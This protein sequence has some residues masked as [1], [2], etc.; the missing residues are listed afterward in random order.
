MMNTLQ[1]L[2]LI[3]TIVVGI[4]SLLLAI[5]ITRVYARKKSLP[6]LFWSAGLW[7][8]TVSVMLEIAFAL[9]VYSAALI[10]AY[11]FLV[12]ILVELLS[13]GSIQLIKNAN[14]KKIYYAFI[15]LVTMYA[16]YTIFSANQ[17]Y[18]IE[19]YVVAGLPTVPAI[20]SSSIATSASA[21]VLVIVAGM[22]YWKKRNNKML[23]IIAGVVIVSVAGSLYIA[24]EPY[25]LYAAEFIGIL[26]LWIG[27]V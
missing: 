20:V 5:Y 8:F 15:I 24:Q 12:V 16:A 11:L 23:S 14:Y 6:H 27:F 26:L 2:V 17:G 4:L 18:L 10:D 3:T 19:N 9:N 7:V 25:L 13:L 1:E 22:S 21:A